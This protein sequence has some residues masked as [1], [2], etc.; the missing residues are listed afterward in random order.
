MLVLKKNKTVTT[1]L[2]MYPVNPNTRAFPIYHQLLKTAVN[3]P[4]RTSFP[5]PIKCYCNVMC[6]CPGKS[7]IDYLEL[8]N[9][10]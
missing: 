1:T 7:F 2:Q 9:P 3:K 6:F 5:F 8:N 4:F 10:D